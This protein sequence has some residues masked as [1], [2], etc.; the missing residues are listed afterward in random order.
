MM[1]V[2]SLLCFPLKWRAYKFFSG[3]HRRTLRR[4]GVTLT[5]MATFIYNYIVQ[6][7]IKCILFVFK[8]PGLA[9]NRPSVIRGD[10]ILVRVKD[11]KGQLEKEEY[12]GFVHNV[13]LTDV[14]LRF[15]PRYLHSS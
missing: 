8:V 9:E 4:S 2:Y 11:S 3:E 10:Q 12:Q 13:G 6:L 7:L 14:R 15:S 5:L 1:H